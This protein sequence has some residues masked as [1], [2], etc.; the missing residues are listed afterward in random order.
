MK[1]YKIYNVNKC[2]IVKGLD[3]ALEIAQNDSRIGNRVSVFDGDKK[4]A[5]YQ[6]GVRIA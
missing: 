5:T 6:F 1:D 3:R 2:F 4:I